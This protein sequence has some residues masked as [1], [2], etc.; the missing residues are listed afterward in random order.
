MLSV[1]HYNIS[2]ISD[3]KT[4]DKYRSNLHFIYHICAF[5]IQFQYISGRKHKNILFRDTKLFCNSGLGDTVFVFSMDRDGIF[6]AN[7]RID[8]FHLFLAGMTGYMGI[9][10]NNLC[11][12]NIQVI[13]N[14][15]NSF[16]ISRNRI[17]TE[18]DQVIWHDLNLTVHAACHTGQCC[19]RLSL[20][21][22]CNQNRFLRRIIF[23]LFNLNQRIIRNL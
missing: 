2:N 21:S 10:E 17:G 3:A 5:I 7:Q 12:L 18:Y 16:F 4:I 14:S 13:D 1:A 8:Q 19:Q 23:Q 6:R 20:A 11:A 22:C 9:V 15:G